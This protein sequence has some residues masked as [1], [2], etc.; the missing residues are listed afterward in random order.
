M[1]R[2][3][4]DGSAVQNPQNVIVPIGTKIREVMEFC[5]GYTEEPQ[6]LIMAAR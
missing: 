6:K 3:T 4:V 1:K 5:G 2:V